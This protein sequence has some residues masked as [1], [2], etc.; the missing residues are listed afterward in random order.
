MSQQ[1]PEDFQLSADDPMMDQVEA[2]TGSRSD[3]DETEQG[4]D[5]SDQSDET[6]GAAAGMGEPNTFEP[7]EV[8]D[9]D[10]LK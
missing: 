6:V 1:P 4:S 10:D 8:T 3:V 7:E 9:D 2:A 5:S